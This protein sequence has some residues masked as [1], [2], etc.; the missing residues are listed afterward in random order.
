MDQR[1]RRQP[2]SGPRID[3]HAHV[4]PPAYLARAR[5]GDIPDVRVERAGGAEVLVVADGPEAGPVAQ[6]IPL[7]AA[8]HDPDARLAA[9][10]AMGVEVQVLSAVQFMYHYWLGGAV[11]AELARLANDG[12]A[13]MAA[14]DRRRFVAMATLPLQDVPAAL[15][16]LERVHGLGMRSVEIGTHVAGAPLDGEALE[17]FWA[18]AAALGTVVFVHPYAPLGRDRLAPY[19]LRNLLGNPFETALA[20]SR[21]FF[22]GVL[23]RHPRL[24][25]CLAHGGG[26]LPAVIGR[27]AQGFAVSPVCRARG[28]AS[29]ATY[30]ARVYYDTI[31][32]DAIA[33]EQLVG[34]VGARQ[35]LMGSDYP[36]DIGDLDPVRTVEKLRLDPAEREAILGGNAAGLLGVA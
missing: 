5:A 29:P 17:P 34:R 25:L 24:R 11:G 3:F 2:L 33:L 16:E 4:V 18:R 20:A 19:F 1:L 6:R 35:V 21:L 27:L 13:A 22:G 23:E 26:A 10:D 12:I 14:R 7:A 28:A 15:A 9:M 30:L 31:T 8:Y 32:H 36:F